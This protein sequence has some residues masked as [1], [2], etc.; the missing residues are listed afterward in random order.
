MKRSAEKYIYDMCVR[1]PN[2]AVVEDNVK[3][4]IE[5][6]I[7]VY[8]SGNKVIICGNGGSAAD[9]LHIVGELMKC[10]VLPRKLSNSIAERLKKYSVN[11]KYLEDNLQMTLPTISLVNEVSLM[12]AYANDVAADL[13]FAQ[14]VLGQGK[15]GDVLLAISTSGNSKNIVYASEVAKALDMNVISLTGKTGGELKRVTD[16]LINVPETETYKIQ[17]LHLPIYHTIC[18]AIES[19]FYA[20]N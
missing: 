6:M 19:E 4:C 3:K 8:K 16:I 20:M 14:Q 10:F 13:N 1:Y 12:T 5:K 11:S 9:S 7:D 2:L 15:K 18:L 17:E